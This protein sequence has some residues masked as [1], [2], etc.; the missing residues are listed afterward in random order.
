MAHPG[1]NGSSR[2][3]SGPPGAAPARHRRRRARRPLRALLA[4]AA[5]AAALAA[6]AL[7]APAAP[8]AQAAPPGGK[9]VTAVLFSW[10]FPSV[11]R[12]CTERLGPAGYGFV[13]VS[14]PQ[15]HIQGSQWWTQ[16][17]PVSYRIAGRLG[18]EQQFRS[19]VATCRAAG[20]GVIVDAVVN[21]MAA[22]SGTGTGGTGYSKYHYPGTYGDADFNTCRTD[23][24]PGDYTGDRW[25]VQHCELVGL[26]DL[27]TGSDHVQNTIADYMNRLL[28]WGVAGFRVDAAKHIPA[29][30]LREI[31]SKVDGGDVFWNQ[32]V[33]YGA[34]EAITPEEYL[35]SGDVQEFRYAF[36]LKR[37]FL[38]ERLAHLRTFGES[39]GYLPSGSAGVFVDNHDTERNG[40]T[41]SYRDGSAYT[42]ASVF[43]LAWPY[44]NPDVH[45]GY[46]FTDFDA[47]PPGGGR[48][49][50]CYQDGWKCQH[51]WPEISAMV[52]FR[53]ATSGAAVTDWWD[54][55]D[56]AIAFGRGDRGFV[57]INGEGGTLDRTFQTSLPG[58]DYCDVHS[59]ATVTVG[60]DGR[61][62]ASVG[63]G[64]ALAL[65]AGARDC[66]G[67]Q[68]PADPADPGS[69]TAAFGV[70]A[71]TEWGES[72]RVVGDHPR[73]GGWDPARAV[74]LSSADYPV[75]RGE[76]SLP[77]GTRIAYK[78]VRVRDGGSQV[79]WESG[80]NRTATVP[81]DG[82]LTL[83][84]TWRT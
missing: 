57:V 74:P 50:A 21:H 59:G 32:E 23:I 80:G 10:D 13:Q 63:A 6:A 41:L 12:E 45:S 76:V 71:T 14:P 47:G 75:W 40:S 3:S 2:T 18:T 66:T 81:T 61:F 15:E 46:E 52:G 7:T 51:A 29:Q 72:I 53:N 60:G 82:T 36:D 27:D 42:L 20:V 31:R 49:D 11:A 83:D 35:G 16:Y 1:T 69:G 68:D 22:G 39:W 5:A 56:D 55:G 30:H 34:G 43:M 26:S 4:G 44:G 38:G 25:R 24:N 65:H 9:D 37:I 17:Q 58:G 77:A 48:V 73:L 28:G 8:T 33:I 19:M 70:H 64:R 78:Y 67:G 54:N 84:D 62:T 79:T